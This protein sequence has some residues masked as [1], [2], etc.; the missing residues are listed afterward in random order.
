MEISLLRHHWN[1]PAPKSR[2]KDPTA[3]FGPQL[4][5]GDRENGAV[6]RVAPRSVEDLR[7]LGFVASPLQCE[8]REHFI[9]AETSITSIPEQLHSGAEPQHEICL[10]LTLETNTK[11]RF[12]LSHFINSLD[13][14]GTSP[15]AKIPRS[16]YRLGAGTG[17]H[18]SG[19]AGHDYITYFLPGLSPPRVLADAHF[20]IHVDSDPDTG[21]LGLRLVR[22][23]LERP[24]R[25]AGAAD[26]NTLWV[27][28]EMSQGVSYRHTQSA[29]VVDGQPSY[30]LL[31]FQGIA[32]RNLPV[33]SNPPVEGALPQAFIPV[34]K[35]DEIAHHSSSSQM[36]SPQRTSTDRQATQDE[37]AHVPNTS[38]KRRRRGSV[39][40]DLSH[41]R[42]KLP[43]LTS[44]RAMSSLALAI[45]SNAPDTFAEGA[46]PPGSDHA[47]VGDGA[48]RYYHNVSRSSPQVP[49]ASDVDVTPSAV[50]EDYVA[51]SQV[52]KNA[53]I[54][55][56][57]TPTSALST[58]NSMTYT[59]PSE[60]ADISC[61][62][63]SLMSQN[64]ALV[65]QNTTLMSQNTVLSAQVTA[66]FAHLEGTAASTD[67]PHSL[68][69]SMQT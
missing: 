58:P 46:I 27:F 35:I 25:G 22:V 36:T 5:P 20:L 6:I 51:T 33:I 12:L 4:W 48:R 53:Y 28:I 38:T 40:A 57:N 37:L 29:S 34:E 49:A 66:I 55:A 11:P 44:Q 65:S 8:R 18:H 10:Q 61:Q 15:R 50:S 56:A 23:G 19:D 1:P 9:L 2:Q 41:R 13:I 67:P 59:L 60:S 68:Q 17:T 14:P 62:I 30:G 7:A 3:R 24:V 21:A 54:R 26:D 45:A 47:S 42:A 31:P 32:T 52:R 64:A 69:T 39:D 63:A 16:T 43:R